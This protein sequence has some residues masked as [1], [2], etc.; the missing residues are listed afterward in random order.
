MDNATE[1]KKLEKRIN[2]MVNEI[3]SHLWNL[4]FQSHIS[5]KLNL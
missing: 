1:K 5:E 2:N 4:L 3:K